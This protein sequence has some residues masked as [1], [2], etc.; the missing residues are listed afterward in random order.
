MRCL[1]AQA[2][3]Q[4]AKLAGRDPANLAHAAILSGQR[5]VGDLEKCRARVRQAHLA[6]RAPEQLDTKFLRELLDG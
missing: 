6:G 2:H 3:V 5:S 4:A 1:A